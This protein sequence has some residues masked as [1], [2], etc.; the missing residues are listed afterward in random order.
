M[1]SVTNT[2]TCT[3]PLCTAMV[4]PTNSGAIVEARAQVLITERS[5][6]PRAATFLA[7]L[8]SIYGP[9]LSERLIL[10]PLSLVSGSDN[11]FVAS[12]AA[13]G[14]ITQ[15]L[16]AP[17]RCGRSG[18]LVT[19]AVTAAVRVVGSIHHYAANSRTDTFMACAAGF[20]DPYILVLLIA[21]NTYGRHAV[22]INQPNFAARQTHLG[23][24][25]LFG[26]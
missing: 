13:A 10:S 22:G 14:L 8:G 21:N 26:Y 20:A 17:W 16:L 9:F 2:G 3:L 1:F 6:A 12:L 4:R 15:C 11:K 5:S 25:A 19:A 24:L 7:S 23:I 18:H